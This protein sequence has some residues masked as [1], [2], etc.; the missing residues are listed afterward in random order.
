M[1]RYGI[2]FRIAA[3]MKS[4]STSWDDLFTLSPDGSTLV[5]STPKTGHGDLY[6]MDLDS[7]QSRRITSG[8][9]YEGNPCYSPDGKKSPIVAKHAFAAISG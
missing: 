2:P 6:A 7:L 4:R 3:D 9:D 5:Y 8:L 1:Y